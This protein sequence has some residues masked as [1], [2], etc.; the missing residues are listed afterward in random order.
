MKNFN[1]V[2]TI[3]NKSKRNTFLIY[4]YNQIYLNYQIK[5]INLYKIFIMQ[6]IKQ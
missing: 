3:Q 5:L 6:T 1:I 4:K 2:F